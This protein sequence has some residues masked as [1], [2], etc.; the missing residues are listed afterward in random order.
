MLCLKKA[1]ARGPFLF[2]EKNP[3]LRGCPQGGGVFALGIAAAAG[4]IG[5]TIANS[6]TAQPERPENQPKNNYN[7]SP[8]PYALNSYLRTPIF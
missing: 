7:L 4:A 8:T 5:A 3:L 6:P 1:S 2:A